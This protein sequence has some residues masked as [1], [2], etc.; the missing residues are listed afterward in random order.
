MSFGQE[1][2]KN[3]VKKDFINRRNWEISPQQHCDLT[4]IQEIKIISASGGKTGKR[5]EK[6]FIVQ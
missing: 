4:K 1:V 2:G 3:N 6:V 5:Q